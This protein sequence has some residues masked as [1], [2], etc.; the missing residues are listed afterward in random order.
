MSNH[1]INILLSII[2]LFLTTLFSQKNDIVKDKVYS[3]QILLDFEE[4]ADKID[5]DYEKAEFY[6]TVASQFHRQLESLHLKYEGVIENYGQEVFDFENK[7]GKGHYYLSQLKPN[8]SYK[9]HL[10]PIDPETVSRNVHFIQAQ[11]LRSQFIKTYKFYQKT[12]NNYIKY[13]DVLLDLSDCEEL[14]Q[15]P[16]SLRKR[17]TFEYSIDYYIDIPHMLQGIE[18]FHDEID[19]DNIIKMTRNDLGQ[20]SSIEWLNNDLL[21]KNRKYI[22]HDNS[23]LDKYVDSVDGKVLFEADYGQNLISNKYFDYVFSAG[24]VPSDYDHITEIYYNKLNHPVA[25]QITLING[26]KLGTIYIKYNNLGHVLSEIWVDANSQKIIREY[27]SEFDPSSGNYKLTEKDR[28][29]NIVS[30]EIVNSMQR[31]ESNHD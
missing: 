3:L 8:F 18:L 31:F 7:L 23:L 17:N 11:T 28:H 25:Y 30:Q 22:Y 27:N 29:G 4:I 2:F 26:K 12:I 20:V 21:K 24:F 15:D 6:S 14:L 19:R 9:Y 13:S 16:F 10:I 1:K 5:S